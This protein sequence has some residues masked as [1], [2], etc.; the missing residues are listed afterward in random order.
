MSDER[1]GRPGDAATPGKRPD[2]AAAPGKRPEDPASPAGLA[3]EAVTDTAPRA[4]RR[5]VLGQ[6][7]R[8]LTF[9]HW[10]VD[11]EAVAGLLPP[12]TRP[13]T[14]EGW[15][16]VGLVPFRMER[17]GIGRGPGIPYLGTFAETNVRLY[18]VDAAGRRGVVFRSLEAARLPPVLVARAAFALPYMWARMD[19][20]RLGTPDAPEFRYTTRRRAP[21]P[22]GTGGSVHIR[23]GAPVVEPDPLT[24]FLTAR[25]GLHVAWHGRTL[26]LPNTHPRWP[27]HEAELLGLD[28]DLVAAAGLPTPT[29]PPMSVLYSPGVRAHFGPPSHCPTAGG[30]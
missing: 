15:T 3:P 27:L 17:V 9:L 12:G 4:L 21:G 26:Y 8:D 20:A 18:S 23:V 19:V 25:W 30:A 10:A 28:D 7:W 29:G 13:D 1:G 6:G 16:Y 22:R 5:T 2:D 24:V 14:H 11:P